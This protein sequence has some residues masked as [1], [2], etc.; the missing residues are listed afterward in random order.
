MISNIKKF[1]LKIRYKIFPILWFTRYHSDSI[2]RTHVVANDFINAAVLKTHHIHNYYSK[3]GHF[4]ID[5]TITD[6]HHDGETYSSLFQRVNRDIF[7]LENALNASVEDYNNSFF[8]T[9]KKMNELFAIRTDIIGLMGGIDH[10]L[11]LLEKG[12]M[13]KKVKRVYSP[14]DPYG[15]ENWEE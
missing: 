10:R 15:E 13:K 4:F 14:V 5:P 9:N 3:P 7:L 2:K 12:M 1:I 11:T 8:L 6:F